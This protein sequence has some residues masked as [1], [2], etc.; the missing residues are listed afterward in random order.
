MM[1]Q[2]RVEP[3]LRP[4][5]SRVP[6]SHLKD[7]SFATADPQSPTDFH[8]QFIPHHEFKF[9]DRESGIEF[10]CP[11]SFAEKLGPAFDFHIVPSVQRFPGWTNRCL[12]KRHVSFCRRSIGLSLV[13]VQARQYAVLP[14]AGPPTRSR[15]DMVECHFFNIQASMSQT[16]CDLGVAMWLASEACLPSTVLTRVS[17]AFVDVPPTEC[18]HIR[19]NTVIHDQSDHFR[20]TNSKRDRLNELLIP[21]GNQPGPISPCVLLEIGWVDDLRPFRSHQRQRTSH[22]GDA[23][24]L[25]V[26]IQNKRLS[27]QHGRHDDFPFS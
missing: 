18:D 11:V 1:S 10:H 27:T 16:G 5:H 22:R 8:K 17:I 12:P 2:P 25:P 21:L 15:H 19:W 9:L 7:E 24:W 4:S 14:S 20:Y 13:A 3:G 6:P 23:H 26:P